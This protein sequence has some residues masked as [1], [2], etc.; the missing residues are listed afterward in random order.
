MA[1][2]VASVLKD[3]FQQGLTFIA[4]IGVIFYQNWKLAAVSL[5]VVPV[6]FY[7]MTQMGMRLRTLATRGQENAGDM[8]ST[9]QESLAGIRIV[10]AFGREEAE[11]ARFM[12][13]NRAYLR[14][15]MKAIQVSSVANS[16][17]EVI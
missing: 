2:A 7:T 14:T 13:T 15:T 5:I 17:M 1:N 9:L 4:M 8:A 16:H 12:E 10:K 3:L 6:S 11:G